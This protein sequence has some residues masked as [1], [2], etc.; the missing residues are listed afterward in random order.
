M[1]RA[2]V[3]AKGD[4]VD[5]ATVRDAARGATTV[6][7]GTAGP[8]PKDPA[9]GM[10]AVPVVIPGAEAPVEKMEAAATNA[11]LAAE[12]NGNAANP[13]PP[14]PCWRDGSST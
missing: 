9:E 6:R 3:P 5:G 11:V 13:R 7:A 4:A 8:G 14:P 1:R 2:I 10:I 12:R